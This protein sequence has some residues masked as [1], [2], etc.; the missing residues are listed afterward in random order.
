MIG[1]PLRTHTGFGRFFGDWFIRK[2]TIYTLHRADIV[3]DSAACASI[4]RAVTP[5]GFFCLNPYHQTWRHRGMGSALP[6]PFWNFA[7][8]YSFRFVTLLSPYF[9]LLVLPLHRGCFLWFYGFWF[10]GGRCRTSFL[11][12]FSVVSTS[13]TASQ[14]FQRQVYA[15][16]LT[17]GFTALTSST[18]AVFPHSRRCFSTAGLRILLTVL[19]FRQSLSRFLFNSCYLSAVSTAGCSTAATGFDSAQE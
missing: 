14:L 15:F 6:S 17:A 11:H 10:R 5:Y 16:F 4:W 3:C 2:N 13:E 8:F 19:F 12:R 1:V 18:A 7:E 9:P